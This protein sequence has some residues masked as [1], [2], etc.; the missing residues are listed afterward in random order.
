MCVFIKSCDFRA[1]FVGIY[2]MLFGAYLIVG[3]PI[4]EAREYDIAGQISI[5]SISLTTDVAA[6][7]LRGN[8]LD[9]PDHIAGS[10]SRSPHKTLIIGHSS[11]V[12]QDLDNVQL[13]DQLQ[14]A[15][16]DFIVTNI[17]TLAKTEIDMND[18][19]TT[20]DTDTVIIMTCAG[21]DLGHGDATH[22]LL[23]T[24]TAASELSML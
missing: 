6:L 2:T 10:F 7:T 16:T 23:V 13:G 5:P 15:D 9:T 8:R 12:F 11:T 19:L 4:V 17:T 1:I 24:A 18:L 20:A 14:Y 3:A 22:R 21:T